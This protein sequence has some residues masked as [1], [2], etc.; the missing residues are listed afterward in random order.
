MY[1]VFCWCRID[2]NGCINCKSRVFTKR[3]IISDELALSWG[4]SHR[5][6]R[7]FDEREGQ[8]CQACHMSERVRMLLWSLKKVQPEFTTLHILHL[9]QTN[10]LTQ[11][12]SR[13]ERLVETTYVPGLEFGAE[14]NG[15]SNQDMTRLT[16][17][18]D[19]FDLVIH[20]ETLEHLHDYALALREANRVLR[21]G[22]YQIYSV[23]LLHDRQTRRRIGRD[24]AGDDVPLLP[25]STH[26]LSGEYPVVWE[27]G[28]DFI[29]NRQAQI[30]EIHYNNYWKNPT[31]FTIVEAKQ[32]AS[33]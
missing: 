17:G 26:G 29:R 28:G 9:N 31:V 10:D 32:R 12:I 19:R 33:A 3:K 13:A 23:P 14:V 11:A 27:F 15:L 8:F 25:L 16:F 4:L 21:P 7:W 30:Y 6:R 5:E 24:A 1:R 20:S 18:S 2:S 22:G